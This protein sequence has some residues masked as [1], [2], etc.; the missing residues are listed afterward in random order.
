MTETL[1]RYRLYYPAVSYVNATCYGDFGDFNAA[2]GAANIHNGEKDVCS[3][4][5][6]RLIIKKVLVRKAA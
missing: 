5:R 2:V 1:T 6:P 4:K 3:G